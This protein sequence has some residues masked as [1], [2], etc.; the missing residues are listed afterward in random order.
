MFWLCWSIGVKIYQPVSKLK[1]I[2]SIRALYRQ[3]DN[4]TV[5]D[6]DYLTMKP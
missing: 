6:L 2:A 5:S 3:K 4:D 1:L